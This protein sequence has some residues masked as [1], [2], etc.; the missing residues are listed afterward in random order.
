M[1]E[2]ILI[3]IKN[4]KSLGMTVYGVYDEASKKDWE[5][6]SKIADGVIYDF[7]YAPLPE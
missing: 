3:A 6:I 4:A 5:Q 7:Q 2:D 1:F